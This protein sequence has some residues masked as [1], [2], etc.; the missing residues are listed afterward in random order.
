MRMALS[1][2]RKQV[3]RAHST[4]NEL[5]RI[6]EMVADPS[7]GEILAFLLD[8]DREKA[9]ATSSISRMAGGVLWVA[10]EADVV[11]AEELVRVMD[12]YKKGIRFIG[13][14]VVTKSGS[15]LGSCFDAFF[16]TRHFVL[17][18]LAVGRSILGVHTDTKLISTTAILQ[19]TKTKI[20]VKDA[21][22]K[23]KKKA[24]IDADPALI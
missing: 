21:A 19:V 20:L 8:S 6:A 9:I 5:G 2:M 22:I 1:E 3:V 13:A 18:Q 7:T 4:R 24:E 14:P 17:M 12:V 23:V 10:E 15:G 11:E 16:D